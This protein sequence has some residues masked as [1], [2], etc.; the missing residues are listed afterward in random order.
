MPRNRT[1]LCGCQNLE[2]WK[3]IIGKHSCYTVLLQTEGVQFSYNMIEIL[4]SRTNF[5][6]FQSSPLDGNVN[7][8]Q[9]AL[10][11][12]KYLFVCFQG[13]QDE[14][15]VLEAHPTDPHILL[16]AGEWFFCYLHILTKL[17]MQKC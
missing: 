5:L 17:Y 16:S 8:V 7:A 10:L 13:H 2:I 11:L 12:C 3:L 4:W 6:I 15:F 14:V 1:N 9:R